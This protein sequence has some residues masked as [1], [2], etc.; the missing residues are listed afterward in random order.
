VA[1]VVKEHKEYEGIFHEP[2]TGMNTDH[3]KVVISQGQKLA[4]RKIGK[5]DKKSGKIGTFTQSLL[6]LH[7]S[8][9]LSR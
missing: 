4:L 6:K 9:K 5:Y 8:T 3:V 1:H 7:L 2:E